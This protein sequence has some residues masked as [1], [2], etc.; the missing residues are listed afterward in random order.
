MSVKISSLYELK[1]EIARLVRIIKRKTG[2]DA[3]NVTIQN[4][5]VELTKYIRERVK[6]NFRVNLY[7]YDDEY[8]LNYFTDN[9][10][11]TIGVSEDGTVNFC[12]IDEDFPLKKGVFKVTEISEDFNIILSRLNDKI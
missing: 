1:H 6:K 3:F 10:R 5:L 4:H 11:W 12:Y 7:I 9:V 2:Q 8:T